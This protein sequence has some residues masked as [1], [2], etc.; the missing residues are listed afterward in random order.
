MTSKTKISITSLILSLVVILL[1]GV[2]CVKKSPLLESGI[3]Q[4]VPDIRR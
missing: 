2:G 3:K 1:S 4:E